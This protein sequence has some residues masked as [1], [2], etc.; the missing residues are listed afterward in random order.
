MKKLLLIFAAATLTISGYAFSGNGSGTEKDPYQVTNADELFEVRN[1]LSAF[2]KQMNDIDLTVWLAENTNQYGWP[3]IGTPTLPFNGT[4]DGNTYSI[5]NLN[6]CRPETDY[7]GLFG[8]TVSAALKNIVLINPNIEGANYVG[9]L[10]G[11]RYG[12]GTYSDVTSLPTIQITNC[13]VVGGNIKGS[14][15]VG[16]IIGY[17][18]GY[19][20]HSVRATIAE[21]FNSASVSATTYCGGICGQMSG[22]G[23]HHALLQDNYSIGQINAESY[24]G[25]IIG[26]STTN[27]F[28][29]VNKLDRDRADFDCLRNYVRGT[30][31]GTTYSNGISGNNYA[32]A[33]TPSQWGSCNYEGTNSLSGNICALDTLKGTYRI[34]ENVTEYTN[35]SK[36]DMLIFNAN[37]KLIT[38]EDN[39]QQGTSYSERLL[40]KV[41][42]YEGLGWD[43]T[44][45]W[46]SWGENRYLCHINQVDIPEIIEF[47]ASSKATM[48]GTTSLESGSI[49][50]IVNGVTY[51]A[52]IA[53]K[54]WEIELGNISPET[55]AV[56]F[57]K[58][59][60]KF[61]SY[62]IKSFAVE[63]IV[64]PDII[65]GDANGDGTIDA[66]DVVSIVNHLLG[67]TSSS[68]NETNADV[69]SDGQ[70]L[71]DDAVGTVQII[72]NQQ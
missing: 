39:L 25:G 66:A 55:P 11:A 7:V 31:K 29:F 13:Y 40:Q 64:I 26:Y 15:N 59:Q 44:N 70:V 62:S 34:G 4:Y 68:F 53:D 20:N 63:H 58:Q 35:Y 69:N 33:W 21:C 8:Y 72:M 71:I 19:S 43:F 9:G 57:A 12:D 54:Q 22:Q 51:S 38:V 10:V 46:K 41:S 18:F 60:G 1:E 67:K 42:T 3:P 30:V 61:P 16:G 47:N 52:P 6:I 28:Y 56:V 49:Y 2:Y 36:A 17:V 65:Q 24:V 27:G 45:I 48:K 37:N 5:L 14:T 32:P 23:Q 50:A